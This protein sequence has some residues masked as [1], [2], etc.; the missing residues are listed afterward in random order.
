MGS[1]VVL[2]TA[3]LSGAVGGRRLYGAVAACAVVVYVGALWNRFAVDDL[4]IIVLN[5]LVADPAGIWRAFAAPYWPP[6][7]GGHMYRPLVIATYA[8]DRLVDGA[9]WFHAVNLLWHAGVAVAVAALAR[10]WADAPGALVAGLLFAVHPVHVEAVA[11]VVGRAELMAALFTVLAVYAGVVR[12]SI[13]WSAAA[14]GLGLLSKENAAVAP[15]LIGLAWL[16]G[17]ARPD[18]RRMALFLASW[19]IVGGTYA[20]VRALVR[21]PFAGYE[22]IAPMFVGESPFTV[23][24]TAV[25]GLAEVTRLLVF[26]LMLRVDYSPAER[27]VVTTPVDPR[28]VAG[29]LCALVWA[30]LLVLAWRRGRKLEAFGLGWIGIAFLPVANL[31]YPAGFYV[32]ERTLY[33]PSV[34]FVLVAAA[35]LARLPPPRRLG[36]VV[37]VLVLSGGVRTALRVPVWRSDATVTLSVLDDSPRSYVGPKRMTALYLDH[38]QPPQALAAARTAARLYDRD[39]GI[40]VTGAVAAFAAGDARAADSLLAG[41]ERLCRGGCAAYYRREAA[42]ARAHGYPVAADSLL[43]RLNRLPAP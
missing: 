42:V 43:G 15:A 13:G 10:R 20:A 14:L 28:F 24:L 11:N 29:L 9:A 32:A 30:G 19:V 22:S 21:H 25:H 5:P 27:T 7:L 18:R 31:L 23:R 34:G 37:A 17:L 16:L 3:A 4:P 8:L 6:D 35:W 40:F 38:H 26:P 36:P 41:L 2:C 33:L 39:A 12:Q 1:L